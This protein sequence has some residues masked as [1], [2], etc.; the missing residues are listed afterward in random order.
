M[1]SGAS[2]RSGGAILGAEDAIMFHRLSQNVVQ[3][4]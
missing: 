3:D 2:R 4:T 1:T